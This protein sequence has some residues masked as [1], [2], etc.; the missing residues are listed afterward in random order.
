MSILI[1]AT[2]NRRHL[3]RETWRDRAMIWTGRMQI[4]TDLIP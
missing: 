1:Y 4:F 3:I 2:S